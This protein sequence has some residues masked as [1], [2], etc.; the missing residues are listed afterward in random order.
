MQPSVSDVD[1][2]GQ[3]TDPW[4][5]CRIADGTA[6]LKALLIFHAHCYAAAP[7]GC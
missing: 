4:L 7:A 3:H 1:A 5:L 6:A 2:V